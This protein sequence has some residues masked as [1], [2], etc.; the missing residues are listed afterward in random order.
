MFISLSY[1]QASWSMFSMTITDS[2]FNTQMF[3]N[4]WTTAIILMEYTHTIDLTLSRSWD[5]NEKSIYFENLVSYYSRYISLPLDVK[6]RQYNFKSPF[7]F[8][9]LAIAVT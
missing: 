2:P 6:I 9:D 3:L 8:K 7:I 1:G 5:K 4:G